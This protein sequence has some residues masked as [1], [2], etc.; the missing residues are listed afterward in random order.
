M[1]ATH[2]FQIQKGSNLGELARDINDKIGRPLSKAIECSGT[3][4]AVHLAVE[5]YT[6]IALNCIIRVFF[7][8]KHGSRN[9]LFLLIIISLSYVFMELMSVQHFEI[10]L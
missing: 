2:T 10:I 6:E 9:T 1:G 5:V 8:R 7:I 3:E 4:S